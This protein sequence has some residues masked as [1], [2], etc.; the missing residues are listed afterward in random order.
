MKTRVA[1]FEFM[2]IFH[3]DLTGTEARPTDRLGLTGS[4]AIQRVSSPP[5]CTLFVNIL[6]LAVCRIAI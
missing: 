4:A 5:T 3:E 2:R 6:G 1:P